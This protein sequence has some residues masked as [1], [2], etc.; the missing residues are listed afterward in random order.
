MKGSCPVIGILAFTAG[1][2]RERAAASSAAPKMALSVL[3]SLLFQIVSGVA[4]GPRKSGG[5]AQWPPVSTIRPQSP[6][7]QAALIASRE[8]GKARTVGIKP[9]RPCPSGS[10]WGHRLKHTATPKLQGPCHHDTVI[11]LL[12]LAALTM[13]AWDPQACS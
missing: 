11:F 2:C 8:E 13:S 7:S 10:R 1:I 9:S 6:S 4:R 3:H 12:P 5:S